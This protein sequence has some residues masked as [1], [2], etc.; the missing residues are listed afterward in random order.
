MWDGN[1]IHVGRGVCPMLSRGSDVV[2]ISS[3][4]SSGVS[5]LKVQVTKAGVPTCPHGTHIHIG[6]A[7]QAHRERG[8]SG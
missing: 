2:L 4:Q 7:S 1:P 3:S 5:D 8:R 6:A